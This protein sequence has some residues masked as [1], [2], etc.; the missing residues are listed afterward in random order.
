MKHLN[1]ADGA[2]QT[3]GVPLGVT[4]LNSN[5]ASKPDVVLLTAASFRRLSRVPV[6][7]PSQLGM[8]ALGVRGRTRVAAWWRP[9][10]L[11]TARA[12]SVPRPPRAQRCG[13]KDHLDIDLDGQ[14]K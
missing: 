5:V 13:S 7:A 14:N 12:V 2:L 3:N 1:C 6:L 8:R 10:S 11:L 9:Q 4:H